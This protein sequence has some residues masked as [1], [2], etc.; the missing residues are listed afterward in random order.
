MG[1]ESLKLKCRPRPAQVEAFDAGELA[2]EPPRFWTQ[3]DRYL[4]RRRPAPELTEVLQLEL[5]VSVESKTID[6]SA[7]SC[8]PYQFPPPTL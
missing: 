8:T 4:R 2:G 6:T 1:Q 3:V 5:D 7:G